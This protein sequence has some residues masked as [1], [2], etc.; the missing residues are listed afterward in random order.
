VP[1]AADAHD[2]RNE[3]LHPLSLPHERDQRGADHINQEAM[4][5]LRAEQEDKDREKENGSLVFLF[6]LSN[7]RSHFAKRGTKTAPAPSKELFLELKPK[8]RLH[9]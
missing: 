4:C 5:G 2:L 6:V 8:K 9:C 1:D 7:R 3:L